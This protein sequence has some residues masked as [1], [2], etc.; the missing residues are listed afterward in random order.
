MVGA[1]AAPEW[2]ASDGLLAAFAKRRS[3]ARKRYARFVAD[4]IGGASVWNDLKG[5][6]LLGHEGFIERSLGHARPA[7]DVNIPKA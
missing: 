3:T 5:Q 7:D 2:L 6:V 1:E 4:G